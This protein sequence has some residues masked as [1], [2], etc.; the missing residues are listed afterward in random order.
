MDAPSHTLG[1]KLQVSSSTLN[2]FAAIFDRTERGS[3]KLKDF[4]RAMRELGFQIDWN[5]HQVMYTPPATIS[6]HALV[7]RRAK[8]MKGPQKHEAAKDLEKYYQWTLDTFERR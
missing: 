1:Q 7:V 2:V 3:V 6:T 5:G 4:D 8:A